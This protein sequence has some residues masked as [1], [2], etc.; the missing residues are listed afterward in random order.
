MNR[1]PLNPASTQGGSST[2]RKIEL[3]HFNA[4]GGHRA[5]ADALKQVLDQAGVDRQVISTNVA[6]MA[7]PQ[8][9]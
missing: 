7:S 9:T 3:I 4:V 2:R 6:G 5:A 8:T 1:D